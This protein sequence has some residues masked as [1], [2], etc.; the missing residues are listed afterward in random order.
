MSIPIVP[1]NP[2]LDEVEWFVSTFAET[3]R[4]KLESFLS[5]LASGV[6]DRE[7]SVRALVKRHFDGLVTYKQLVD[8]LGALFD[9]S[10]VGKT[11]ALSER[12]HE[13][14]AVTEETYKPLFK[15][16]RALV[17]S[18]NLRQI[19]EKRYGVSKIQD[20][21]R[22]AIETSDFEM[23]GKYW[24]DIQSVKGSTM[25][26]GQVIDEKVKKSLENVRESLFDRVTHL[27][28]DHNNK[29]SQHV[30]EA[31]ITLSSIGLPTT[32][33]SKKDDFRRLISKQLPMF[34]GLDIDSFPASGILF[35]ITCSSL[36]KSYK[37]NCFEHNSR[38]K[39][40]VAGLAVDF[41]DVSISDEQSFNVSDNLEYL[42]FQLDSDCLSEV[43]VSPLD[44]VFSGFIQGICLSFSVGGGFVQVLKSAFSKIVETKNSEFNE[45]FL[46]RLCQC[47][48]EILFSIFSN[49]LRNALLLKHGS[50]DDVKAPNSIVS[51]PR[52]DSSPTYLDPSDWVI[53]SP[54]SQ[55][56]IEVVEVL[57]QIKN[58]G[59]L[60]ST[61]A[62]SFNTLMV[63][64][65]L[66]LIKRIK[67][68]WNKDLNTLLGGGSQT[69][70]SVDM[71]GDKIGHVL[72]YFEERLEILKKLVIPDVL[73]LSE[74]IKR[75]FNHQLLIF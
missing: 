32:F 65:I 27:S 55:T 48:S 18:R 38:F 1:D 53:V 22:Q 34:S 62:L 26:V 64:V 43:G 59:V 4:E 2:D 6:D 67:S 23:I 15:Q 41:D 56:L 49:S 14:L 69:S 71:S 75:R 63:D 7:A 54:S 33:R 37:E 19:H 16:Y 73:K 17:V 42:S 30:P 35:L 52:G 45:L 31:I 66:S 21:L 51:L 29:F 68:E 70:E 39:E 50:N 58:R 3:S 47:T 11:K 10:F 44:S 13:Q 40:D 46:T 25:F 5:S 72:A 60:S 28:F 8:A 12:L 20:S 36:L 9:P 24:N 61:S 74:G 57:E